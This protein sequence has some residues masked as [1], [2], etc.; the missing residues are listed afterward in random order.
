MPAEVCKQMSCT[1]FK[2]SETNKM[3]DDTP[4]KVITI[5]K[6]YPVRGDYANID[7]FTQYIIDIK[8]DG[9]M[10]DTKSAEYYYYKEAINYFTKRMLAILSDTEKYVI[11]VIPAHTKGTSASGVRKIA[12]EVCSRLPE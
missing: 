4:E 8:K 3:S 9:E 6:Y 1:I 11:C 2:N 10:L 5:G 12:K 7:R